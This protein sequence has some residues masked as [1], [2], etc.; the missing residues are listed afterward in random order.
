MGVLDEWRFCPRCAAPIRVERS[1]AECSSCGYVMYANPATSVCA[2]VVRD[3]RVLLGRR[4]NEPSAGKW[5]V[6]GGFVEEGEEALDAL[7]RELREETGLTIEV[8]EFL[9][10]FADWYGDRGTLNLYWT[11]TA[12]G[13]PKAADD[14]SELAWF[15]RNE[16]PPAGEI[17]FANVVDVLRIWQQET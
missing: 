15:R 2:L 10:A 17:A 7:R 6:P 5:D 1:R 12:A 13:E 11:A 3:Q 14:V 9:G 4:A 16:L 8:Q